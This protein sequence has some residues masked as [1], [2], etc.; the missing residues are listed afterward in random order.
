MKKKKF[1][2][3]EDVELVDKEFFGDNEAHYYNIKCFDGHATAHKADEDDEI[4]PNVV[5]MTYPTLAEVLAD[6]EKA[7]EVLDYRG[8]WD[9]KPSDI[10]YGDVM[11]CYGKIAGSGVT[12]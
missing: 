3:E 1:Y 10:Q 9:L 12:E 2:F 7:K 5:E 11:M 8:L 6:K 4:A